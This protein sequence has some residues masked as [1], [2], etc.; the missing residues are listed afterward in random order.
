M[1][2]VGLLTQPEVIEVL[3]KYFVPVEYDVT[4]AGFVPGDV[5]AMSHL[6]GAWENSPWTRVSFGSEWVLEPGGEFLLSTGFHKHTNLPV[7]KTFQD[8]LETALKRFARLR[9]HERGSAEEQ[10]EIAKIQGE[11]DR[12]MK[13]FRPCWLDY[14]IGTQETLSA[15]GRGEPRMFEKKL[16]GVFTYPD[17]KVRT[18]VAEALGAFIVSEHSSELTDEQVLFLEEQVSN[19][20]DDESDVVRK[21][22]ALALHQ[23]EGQ[24]APAA[25]G[26]DLVQAAR[27]LW[28]DKQA[29]SN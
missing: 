29:A 10:E 22:A 19:L 12:D 28:A 8:S 6:K 14:R 5:P 16:S 18:Q 11:I 2:R 25:E 17:P 21:A 4:A 24:E 3:N 13:E 26:E 20:L 7:A 27:A 23:F 1:V 9:A 15:L